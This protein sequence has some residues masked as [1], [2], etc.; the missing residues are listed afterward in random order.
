MPSVYYTINLDFFKISL[1][2][3]LGRRFGGDGGAF[4][5][6]LAQGSGGV[7]RWEKTEIG[8][9]VL[10]NGDPHRPLLIELYGYK[11]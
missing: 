8:L 2:S 6:L 3:I 10:A 9:P 1:L 5:V 11:K 4:V 7:L